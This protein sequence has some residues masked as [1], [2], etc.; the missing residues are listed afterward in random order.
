MRSKERE[1]AASVMENSNIKSLAQ[2]L[3]NQKDG[4]LLPKSEMED[5]PDIIKTPNKESVLSQDR[6][7]FASSSCEKHPANYFSE[8]KSSTPQVK[9]KDFKFH[10]KH[11]SLMKLGNR[12]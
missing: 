8:V 9:A 7:K 2:L 1:K 5:Y 10:V 6:R 4:K 11:S 12:A 3:K